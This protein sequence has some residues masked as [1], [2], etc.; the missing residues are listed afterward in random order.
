MDRQKRKWTSA[1]IVI[2]GFAAVILLGSLLLTLPIAT[3]D[4]RGADW[5][6]ALFTATSA[7]CVTGLVVRDTA[8]YW[9]SFGQGVLLLLV[10][11]GGLGVVTVSALFTL[12]AGRKIGF[13]GRSIL[14]EA[15]SAPQVG[16]IVRLVGFICRGTLIV[17]LAGAAALSPVFCRTFGLGKGLWYSLFHAVS[18]FCN[19]GFDLMGTPEAPFSSLTGFA[20]T[21]LVNV[22]I[23]A[24]IVMGGIGFLTWRDVRQHGWHLHR[25][26]M[27]SKVV[28][29]VSALLIALPALYL[30]WAEFAGE[31]LGR[32]IWLSLFQAVTPRTAG[33]NTADLTT[34]SEGGTAI[35]I[36][37]MLVGGSPSS[38]AGGMKTTTLMVLLA[39]AAAVF[40]RREQVCLFSRRVGEETVR[41]AIALLVLYLTLFLVGGIAISRVEG[42]PL[43][44]CLYEAASAVGTV[45]LTLGLT[46]TLGGLSRIILM[47]L[48]FLGRVGGLTLVFA[49]L[50]PRRSGGAQL[51]L[52]R[53]VVG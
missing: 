32:R 24:L 43:L 53:L 20:E 30:F 51:P 25:Y 36:L 2:L 27:Q 15:V 42:V 13:R 34:L 46:P 28:L 7:V 47:G 22:T 19:A 11:V 31:P 5:G 12:A 48:M 10:Q 29:S 41:S 3:R 21:P 44:P 1:Q 14:Q 8:T 49:A 40:Q 23:M 50:S 35:T 18:A 4:G 45:G 52:G 6:D 39:T 33:F 16:G 26:E 37:L 38:T 9:S 17:E